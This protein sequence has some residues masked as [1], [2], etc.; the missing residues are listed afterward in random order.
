MSPPRVRLQRGASM[1][2]ASGMCSKQAWAITCTPVVVWLTPPGDTPSMDGR[3]P[4]MTMYGFRVWTG[5]LPG[6]TTLGLAGSRSNSIR[7]LFIRMPVAGS[8][9]PLPK[10]WNT[11]CS[12]A[13]ALPWPSASTMPAVSPGSRA[14]EGAASATLA[15]RRA[16]RAGSRVAGQVAAGSATLRWKVSRHSRAIW[17]C[18]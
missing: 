5:R 15:R 8:T 2:W 14:P 6:P 17:I 10:G 18:A 16:T 11:L 12:M 7:R 13:S 1:A 4:S 9:Q 3:P